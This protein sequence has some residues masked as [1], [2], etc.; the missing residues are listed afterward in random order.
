MF[1][2]GL[3]LLLLPLGALAQSPD[4]SAQIQSYELPNGTKVILSPSQEAKTFQ[5]R[6]G[7]DAGHFNEEPGKAGTAHLLEHYLFTDAKLAPDQ[8][9]LE[10][11]REK[12]GS[13]NATT[14]SKETA[15]FATVPSRLREWIVRTMGQ[16]LFN[17]EFD[18]QRVTHAKGPVFVEI[19]RPNFMDYL[20][21]TASRLVPDFLLAPNFWETE[22]GVREPRH[23]GSSAR[24]DTGAISASD[25]EHFYKRYYGPANLTVMVSGAFTIEELSPLLQEVFGARQADKEARIGWKDPT[26]V[27]RH[28]R[29]VHIS[30]TSFTPSIELGTKVSGLSFVDELALRVYLGFLSHRLMKDLRNK[31]GETYTV[32]PSFDLREGSGKAIIHLEAPAETYRINL[33]TIQ[34]MFER[35][36]RGG[37]VSPQMFEEAKALYEKSFALTDKDSGTMMRLAQRRDYVERNYPAKPILTDYQALSVL[38]HAK[39][40]ES[41]KRSFD[42]EMKFESLEKPPALFRFDPLIFSVASFAFWM[43][44]L[45]RW[46]AHPFLHQRL[47]WQRKLS[48]PPVY[49]L[50]GALIFGSFLTT[51]ALAFLW[52][53]ACARWGIPYYSYLVLDYLNGFLWCGIAILSAQV[54]LGLIC[55]KLTVMDGVLIAKSLGLMSRVLPL[56]E[57]ANIELVR[58]FGLKFTQLIQMRFWPN[59]YD[60]LFWRKGLL[61]RMKS[62]RL[63]YFSVRNPEAS[64]G[65]LRLL[66]SEYRGKQVVEQARVSGSAA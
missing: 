16:L 35:E 12:G 28:S 17:K 18:S 44:V 55:R 48:F 24:V 26:P 6:V 65:E 64:L 7:I 42:P 22:F 52:E 8:T 13:A 51:L 49:M 46:L 29:L 50:Q 14:A 61:V 34:S 36:V 15:Y 63:Y 21:V 3:G 47:R 11:I 59:Y 23:I 38:T 56:V 30:A 5:I 19:G 25:L 1:G 9:Y 57:I 37:E 39:W 41:L 31:K 27:A 53:R 58:P 4:P 43:I 32:S 10:A 66:L 45:R 20:L 54:F 62:G 33:A 2:L 60:P 40:L